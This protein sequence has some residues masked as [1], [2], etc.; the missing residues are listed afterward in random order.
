LVITTDSSQH[1]DSDNSLIAEMNMM[2]TAHSRQES[3][4]RQPMRKFFGFYQRQR[5]LMV[6]LTVIFVAVALLV[7]HFLHDRYDA[8]TLLMLDQ[9]QTQSSGSKVN[10][11]PSVESEIEIMTSDAI[12]QKVA[13][14]LGLAKNAKPNPDIN[15]EAVKRPEDNP[16][17]ASIDRTVDRLV[18]VADN[19]NIKV[20]PH[21]IKALKKKIKVRKRGKSDVIAVEATANSP[22]EAARLSRV[23]TKVYLAEHVRSKLQFIEGIERALEE[24]VASLRKQGKSSGAGSPNGSEID[25]AIR[26]FSSQYIARHKLVEL[27][28]QAVLPHLRVASWA[29]EPY[30]ASFPQRELLAVAGVLAAIQLAIA[31]ALLVDLNFTGI[32]SSRELELASGVWNIG[33]IPSAGLR[34]ARRKK[35]HDWIIELPSSPF[36][37]SIHKLYNGVD[38]LLRQHRVTPSVMV[39]GMSERIRHDVIAVALARSAALSG[40]KVVI[41][42][43][44]TQVSR[45]PLLMSLKQQE[46][47]SD[48]AEEAL[49][50]A[51]PNNLQTDPKTDLK[52]LDVK[53]GGYGWN[54]GIIHYSVFTGTLEY[55]ERNFDLVVVVAPSLPQADNIFMQAVRTGLRLLVVQEGASMED[56]VTN[57][58]QRLR[59]VG[60]DN[61][62][63]ALIAH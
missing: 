32:S 27:N 4:S 46:P 38:L 21:I 47:V 61:V 54:D 58:V 40:K 56:E 24:R 37:C 48:V 31:I 28:R 3:A 63:T 62:V 1:R 60:G 7:V 12:Y 10:T 11:L 35:C 33:L 30:H 18:P 57:A 39:T 51:V 34:R 42:S 44:E 15:D 5:R 6:T 8:A 14:K 23:F 59:R 22:K 26:N 17:T 20:P 9:A 53:Q 52:V 13:I 45:L 25:T 2:N 55:L 50:Q 19:D 16:A 49:E 41:V 43:G 29:V 36:S